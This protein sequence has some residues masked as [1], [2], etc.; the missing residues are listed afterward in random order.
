MIQLE[1]PDEVPM[2]LLAKYARCKDFAYDIPRCY[3]EN[4]S[5]EE[6]VLEHVLEYER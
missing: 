5:K 1:R 2:Q 6:L 3:Y 4:T